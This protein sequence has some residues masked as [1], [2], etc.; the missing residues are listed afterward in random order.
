MTTQI[1]TSSPLVSVLVRS[2]DRASLAKALDSISH[3]TYPS[4][5]ILVVAASGS[6]H[7]PLPELWRGRPLR[8]LPSLKALS[9]PDAANVLVA[10]AQGQYLNFL[11]DDD[12]LLSEHIDTLVNALMQASGKRLAYSVCRVYDAQ[13]VDSGRLGKSSHHL[14]MFHQNRFAIH[15]ALFN[16]SLIDQGVRFDSKFDRLEDLDFFIACGARTAFEFVPTETCIWNAFTGQSGMGFAGNFDSAQHERYMRVI[17]E[18]WHKQFE[19]WGR[20]PEG[21]LAVAESA[22]ALGRR[23]VSAKLL[24]KIRHTVWANNALSARVDALTTLLGTKPA[25]SPQN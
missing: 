19:K 14:L 15:A 18:K 11:D 1:K 12:E 25:S 2:T 23:D 4:I 6:A 16:R 9:R 5:E 17:R 22:A 13:G 8:F 20:D 3:Q 10:S 7:A 21:I 24:A